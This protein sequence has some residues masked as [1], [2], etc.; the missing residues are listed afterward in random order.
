MQDD[1]RLDEI[2]G[3]YATLMAAAAKSADPRLERVFKLV[4]R[5]AFFPPGPWQIMTGERYH[6]TPSADPI[7]LYQ[8]A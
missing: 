6:T 1:K 7:Y 5:Q 3:F 8:N 2:A 4:P